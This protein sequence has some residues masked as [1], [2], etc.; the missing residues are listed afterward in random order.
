MNSLQDFLHMGGYAVYVWPAYGLAAL[1]MIA[2]AVLPLRRLRK[3]LGELRGRTAD[4]E[5]P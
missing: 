4:V 1:V 5:K 2:N 3:Q